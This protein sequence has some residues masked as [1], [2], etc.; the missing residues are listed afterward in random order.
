M[1]FKFVT[2]TAQVV[3][4]IYKLLENELCSYKKKCSK[5]CVFRFSIYNDVLRDF[6]YQITKLLHTTVLSTGIPTI[7]FKNFIFYYY[8]YP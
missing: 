7:F 8:C 2:L 5:I 3:F 4:K 1:A 6:I